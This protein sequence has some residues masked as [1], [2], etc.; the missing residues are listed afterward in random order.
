[1]TSFVWR[2]KERFSLRENRKKFM[3]VPQDLKDLLESGAH[4]GHQAR[5]WNPRMGKY[6]FTQRDNV[7]I[8]D[9]TITAQKLN[10]A[11]DV[12][13]KAVSEGKIV[14]FVGTKRQ[15]K[16]IV[17]EEALKV[18]APFIAERWLG[19][20][21]TNWEEISKRIAKL[22]KMKQAMEAG[23]YDTF[24]KKER[25]LIQRDIDRL[26]RFLGGISDLKRTPD[27]LFVV[28]SVKEKVAV[29]EAKVKGVE[30]IAM[31]DSN[32]DPDVVDYVIPCNDD[33]VRSIKYV[34]SRISE[35]YAEGKAKSSK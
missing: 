30:V 35:A 10:D 28:D 24:T 29:D 20:T 19:G 15:A 23:E 7:H 8:F 13:K 31:V 12:I 9:L 21:L 26:E 27:Y 17:R 33:A 11:C 34:V 3:S 16:A 14:V 18:G 2:N 32:G 22:N 5:R 1:M 25:V 4:F 6:I